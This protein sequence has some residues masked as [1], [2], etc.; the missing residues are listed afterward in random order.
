MEKKRQF[1]ANWPVNQRTRGGILKIRGTA[2]HPGL[3]PNSLAINDLLARKCGGLALRRIFSG[4]GVGAPANAIPIPATGGGAISP[5]SGETGVQL[6]SVRR[7]PGDRG[8]PAGILV[9]LFRATGAQVWGPVA[10]QAPGPSAQAA[11]GGSGAHRVGGHERVRG[12]DRPKNAM[13]ST[14]TAFFIRLTI[15]LR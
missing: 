9:M 8:H 1:A 2:R 14:S 4:T 10:R 15:M 3:N 12:L 11:P 6:E 13:G 5:G 7:P